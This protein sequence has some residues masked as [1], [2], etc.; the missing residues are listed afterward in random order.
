[1]V[2]KK[3]GVGVLAMLACA[4]VAPQVPQHLQSLMRVA[5][6]QGETALA[7]R[8][9]S[10]QPCVHFCT[11][12]GV[13]FPLLNSVGSWGTQ[14]FENTNINCPKDSLSK[15]RQKTKESG[16]IGSQKRVKSVMHKVTAQQKIWFCFTFNITFQ[17]NPKP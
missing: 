8:D 10:W 15:E 3:E 14:G 7:A 1:M 17:K 4:M 11:Q 12:L 9:T 2:C 6:S 16:V 5:A 13:G